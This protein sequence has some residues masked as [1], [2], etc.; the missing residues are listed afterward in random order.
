MLFGTH[1]Y[2][3]LLSDQTLQHK[4][5]WLSCFELFCWC[6]WYAQEG[7]MQGQTED[8]VDKRGTW[9]NSRWRWGSTSC[10]GRSLGQLLDEGRLRVKTTTLSLMINKFWHVPPPGTVWSL[11]LTDT[12]A[13][14]RGCPHR[15]EGWMKWTFRAILHSWGSNLYQRR[16][17]IMKLKTVIYL[18]LPV[19][20]TFAALSPDLTTVFCTRKWN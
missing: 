10:S 19:L 12:R 4:T 17:G 15:L 20:I 5:I 8:S 18:P 6:T 7:R 16:S 9:H 13:G 1:K 3:H 2:H 11:K 14:T